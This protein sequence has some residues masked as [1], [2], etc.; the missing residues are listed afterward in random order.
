MTK[1]DDQ[2]A[3]ILDV[4]RDLFAEKG[5]EGTTTRELNKALGIADGLLYY[6]FPHGKQEIL[7]TIVQQGVEQRINEVQVDFAGATTTDQLEVRFGTIIRQIWQL[8]ASEDN[9]QSFMITVRERMLL[10]DDE[11]GW[12]SAVTTAVEG[13]ICDA[14]AAIAEE[15]GW[16]ETSARMRGQVCMS[17][18]QSK[19][20]DELLIKD[21]RELQETALLGMKAQIHFVLGSK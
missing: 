1:S 15:M 7:D 17:I 8:F 19:L 16:T 4:A 3:K 11:S 18:I 5:F 6:Y 20:Y 14:L 21:H 13:N 9:Y 12:L 2:R 10:S